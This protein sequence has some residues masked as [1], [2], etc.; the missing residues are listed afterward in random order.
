MKE[1][2]DACNN[3]EPICL[4]STDRLT[5]KRR[6]MSPRNNQFQTQVRMRLNGTEQRLGKEILRANS[7][8]RKDFFHYWSPF[9]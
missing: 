6:E 5:M 1:T 8:D 2:L 3:R 4:D 7:C 9:W